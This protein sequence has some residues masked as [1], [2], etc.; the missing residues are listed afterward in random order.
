MPV[1]R[2]KLLH[3]EVAVKQLCPTPSSRIKEW[4]QIFLEGNF[5]PPLTLNDRQEVDLSTLPSEIQQSCSK[6]CVVDD[7]SDEPRFLP[8]DSFIVHTFVLSDE[9]ACTEELEPTGG[10]DEYVSAS[11]SLPLPHSSLDN[12]WESLIFEPGMK[13]QLLDYAQSALIFSDKKVSS[14]IINWNRILLLHGYEIC[15]KHRC[16][17]T[18]IN[19]HSPSVA[20][21]CDTDYP[22]QERQA[23]AGP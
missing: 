11:D 22:V 2:K 7:D 12:L 10:D 5:V 9:E 3:I 16:T 17:G 18:V 13:R 8:R 19:G 21:F 20:P 14:N 23:S 15:G 1:D 4:W 6:A